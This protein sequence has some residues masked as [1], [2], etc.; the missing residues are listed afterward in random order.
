MAQMFDGGNFAELYDMH[1]H[2]TR[3][4]KPNTITYC[5][6][7]YQFLNIQDAVAS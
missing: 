1:I 7:K 2:E 3:F 6:E 4:V 5:F